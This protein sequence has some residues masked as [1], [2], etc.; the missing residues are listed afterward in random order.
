[1]G[2]TLEE[3][4]PGL[5]GIAGE[6]AAG[7]QG[8]A[9]EGAFSGKPRMT[10]ETAPAGNVPTSV[11]PGAGP[12]IQLKEETEAAEAAPEKEGAGEG[13][14]RINGEAR[15]PSL[16]RL[17]NPPGNANMPLIVRQHKKW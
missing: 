7:A 11:M 6:P 16:I 15:P 3:R 14:G 5:V 12:E 4:F 8:T 2:A 17:P 9:P 13:R 10:T 1:M